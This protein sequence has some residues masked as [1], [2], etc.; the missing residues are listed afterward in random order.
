[1]HF[2]ALCTDKPNGLEIRMKHRPEHLAWL[3]A[4]KARVLL[5]GPFLTADG[6]TMTGSMLVIEATDLAD[7]EAFLAQD[8]FAGAGLFTGVEVKPWRRTFGATLA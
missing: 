3:D 5:A 7:A 1:M 2:V 6:Q 8:P 4:H